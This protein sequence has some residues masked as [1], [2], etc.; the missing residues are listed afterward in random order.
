LTRANEQEISRFAFVASRSMGKAVV[1]NR[2]KRLLREAVHHY[3]PDIA[4]GWDCLLIARMGLSQAS[5]AEA[6]SAVFR[7]LTRANLLQKNSD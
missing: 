7:L 3:L 2:A 5:L 4:S 1:R 6:N